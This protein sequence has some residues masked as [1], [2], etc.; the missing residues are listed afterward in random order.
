MPPRTELARL[1]IGTDPRLRRLL[2]YWA[3]TGVFYTVCMSIMWLLIRNGSVERT[4]GGR[5]IVFCM[6]WLVG[7]YGLIRAS[8]VLRIM[9][10]H[11]AV[12][13]SLVALAC[14]V[15]IY[16]LVGPIRGASLM[17]LPVVI[18]FCT[19]SLRPRETLLLCAFAICALAGTMAWMVH[20]DPLRYRLPVEGVHFTLSA[21]SMLAVA[22]L[23]GEMSKLHA[24]LK[25]QKEELL[26]AVATI[27]TLATID[28]LTSLANRRHMNEVLAAEERRTGA[29]GQAVCI[30]LVDIDFFKS[31][32]DRYGHAGGDCVLRAFA[33]AARAG[34]RNADVLARWGGEEFLL[35]LPNTALPEATQVLN[36]MAERIKAMRVAEFDR[37]LAITF[38]GG[39]VE[40]ASGEP[41]TATIVRADR[42]MYVAKS[43][44]RDRV[45]V[46]D[47][48]A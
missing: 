5:M 33:G 15:A 8:N 13:Q 41:F 12:L 43:S 38:S 46:G 22:L 37:G 24:R 20:H 16:S 30:A 1:F 2:G 3:A 10:S 17:V 26:T 35:M 27:R 19:F 36:R 14:N 29:A 31:V 18:V 44:G 21:M 42:A 47:G 9:P 45:V 40:R 25:R 34:L 4:A 11:L 23:T 6:S 28:E 39:L 7:C 48:P 32:N